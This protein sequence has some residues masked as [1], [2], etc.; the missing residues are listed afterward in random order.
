MN[1]KPEFNDTSIR[2]PISYSGVVRAIDSNKILEAMV[3]GCDSNLKLKLNIGEKVKGYIKFDELEYRLDGLKTKDIAAMSKVGRHIQF[4]P[5]SIIDDGNGG[6]IVECSR[7]DAQELCYKEYISKLTP[8]DIIDARVVTAERFG[9]FCD[10]GCGVVALL[11]TN[12]ISATH[13]ID[14]KALFRNNV[15]LKVIV[16]N[17]QAD[18]KIQLSHRE[19]LGTWEEESSKLKPGSIVCGT[20]LS[21]ESYG[22]FIRLT[23]NLSGLAANTTILDK[24]DL[25]SG[26]VV[27]VKVK[28]IINSAD[29]VKRVKLSVLEKIEGAS[30]KLEF[31]YYKTS[32]NIDKW[33]YT[34][35]CKKRIETDFT[36]EKNE[37]S[38]KF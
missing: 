8:G 9:V 11:P 34:E 2:K 6:Y 16:K 21:V 37:L 15:K 23:Q 19:L 27:S 25:Q 28:S 4:I 3:E 13:V 31:N 17:I 18:G 22:A 1:F 24:L 36:A 12:L 7:K 26:D 38:G 29:R 33:I 5:K 32:G 20:V 30:E 10:V 35:D 14:T